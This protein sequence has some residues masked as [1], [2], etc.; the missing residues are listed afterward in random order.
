M[1]FFADNEQTHPSNKQHR[2]SIAE[3]MGQVDQQ[4]ANEP[5]FLYFAP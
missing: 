3:L 4:Q 2:L 1:I 5:S